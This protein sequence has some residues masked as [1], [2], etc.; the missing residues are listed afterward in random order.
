MYTRPKTRRE[1]ARVM[2]H[3]STRLLGEFE[4]ANDHDATA[5][6][7]KLRSLIRKE[8][9]TPSFFLV[10]P[11]IANR[12]PACALR[13]LTSQYPDKS[14]RWIA[15]SVSFKDLNWSTQVLVQYAVESMSEEEPSHHKY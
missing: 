12:C 15:E 9:S 4:V 1:A 13:S 7:V 6:A 8:G 14:S 5:L 2:L 10:D 3:P 11:T